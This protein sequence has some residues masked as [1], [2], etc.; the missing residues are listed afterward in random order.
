M[1]EFT[2]EDYEALLRQI[3]ENYDGAN[4]QYQKIDA[5]AQ[6]LCDVNQMMVNMPNMTVVRDNGGNVIGY[7]YVYTGPADVNTDDMEVDSNSGGSSFGTATGGGGTTRGRGAGRFPGTNDSTNGI[8]SAKTSGGS[9]LV[10]GFI[11]ASWGVVSTLAKFGK[12]VAGSAADAIEKVGEHAGELFN[13]LFT[14]AGD[15]TANVIRALFGVDNNGNTTM[16]LDEDTIGALA[17]TAKDDGCFGDSSVSEITESPQ[18]FVWGTMYVPAYR[19]SPS[20]ISTSG[21]NSQGTVVNYPAVIYLGDGV[22]DGV[23]CHTYINL[24][25]PSSFNNLQMM[26]AQWNGGLE[27]YV[28][29]AC[30]ESTTIN[31]SLVSVI[32]IEI[33]SGLIHN[34]HSSSQAGSWAKR[35]VAYKTEQFWVA[36][37]YTVDYLDSPAYPLSTFNTTIFNFTFAYAW[38]ML[39]GTWGGASVPGISDQSGATSMVDAVTG[40]DPHVVAQNLATQYPQVMGSPVQIVVLD[41]SC[42]EVTKNYYSVPIS[43]SPT[44]L[45]TIAPITGG[46]QVNPS[47]NPDVQ[48]D[49]PDIDMSKYIDQVVNQLR[50]SG[51]GRDTSSIDPTTGDPTVI[52]GEAPNTGSGVTPPEVLPEADVQGVWHIYNPS[53]AEV[54]ALGSWLWSANIIDQIVRMFSNPMEAIIGLHAVYAEPTVSSAQSIVVGNLTSTASARV[55]TKQYA[56][57]DCGSVWL[58]EYF[59]N[60]FDYDPYTKVSLFLPFIGIV[61]LKTA[62]VMR[63]QISVTYNVD[64]YT[65]ACVAMVSVERDGVGGVLYQYSGCCAVEYPVSG[66]N[67]SR[68]LQA[69]FA[70]ASSALGAG[71]MTMGAPGTAALGAIAAG[72]TFMSKANMSVQRSGSFSGNAGAMGIKKPYLIITRPQTNMALQYEMYDGR[73]ANYTRRVGECTGYIKCKEVHLNVPGAYKSELDEIEQL[74]KEGILI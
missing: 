71:M 31:T 8:S 63:A 59:G 53:S 60:V 47:F 13:D 2:K 35:G 41:D 15:S 50:G 65:G 19:I 55:V 57:L 29:L 26:I 27:Y 72:S 33:G 48:L 69:I 14:K 58:T 3:N 6:S 23:R 40:A 73:G 56:S 67:Y 42:N 54:S 5:A 45:T 30:K 37:L 66:A 32:A 16:Y 24:G 28:L 44:N 12:N 49:L 38:Y 18:D 10:S 64:V 9:S 52:E 20:V 21:K 36:Y 39:Y 61:D 22:V 43:Y 46:L 11:D 7:D 25:Q 68:M 74:L 4:A 17:I 51:A 1:S 62:D 34:W 70:S